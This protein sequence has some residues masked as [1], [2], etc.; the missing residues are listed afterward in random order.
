MPKEQHEGIKNYVVN[1]INSML[2]VQAQGESVRRAT[3][4]KLNFVLV[5]VLKHEWPHKY[6]PCASF[7]QIMFFSW[8]T[9][10]SD[11]VGSSQGSELM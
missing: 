11:L 7:S 1:K 10:I 4:G 8:P 6:V 9:F 5:Q 2:S 3:L